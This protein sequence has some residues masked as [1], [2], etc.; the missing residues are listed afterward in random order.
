MA[1]REG[2]NEIG[3]PMISNQTIAASNLQ[4]LALN[5]NLSA[6]GSF[7]QRAREHLRAVQGFGGLPA[8]FEADPQ[9]S[10]TSGGGVTV[11]LRQQFKSIPV[12]MGAQAVRF[13]P[14]GSVESST[15]ATFTI[16]ED[17]PVEPRLSP[18]QAVLEAAKNVA[19]ISAE[20]ARPNGR[21]WQCV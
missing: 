21:L 13:R 3:I 15:G 1:G 2:R 20:S 10:K 8:E 14:D 12:L 17:T 18:A 7:V 5:A 9:A 16:G 6:S 11:H 4:A 19:E